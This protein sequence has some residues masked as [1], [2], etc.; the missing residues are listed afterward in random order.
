VLRGR[1]PG[2]GSTSITLRP[3]QLHSAIRSQVEVLI[4]MKLLGKLD[5]QAI[6]EWVRLHA[7][8]EE[9]RELK[10]SLPSLPVGTGWFWSPGWLEIMAKVHV[11]P[12]RT[13]DSSATPRVGQQRV[14]PRE[15]APVNPADL[16]RLAARLRTA[17]AA[18]VPGKPA[19]DV[20]RLSAELARL[21]AQLAEASQRE[22][23]RV[24]V[25]VL[26][27]GDIAALEQAVTGLRDVAGSIELALS[28]AV[29]PPS[30][31]PVP[32]SAPK[33]APTPAVARPPRSAPA[34]VSA[35]APLKPGA[36]R[37]LEALARRHPLRVTRPQLATLAGMKRTG[38]AFQAYFS[39]L[40]GAGFIAEA[41]G[42][43]SV[44]PD[45]LASAGL[46]P[47]AEPLTAEDLRETWKNTLKPKAWA[48][49]ECLLVAYPEARTK[50][51]LAEAVGMTVTGGGFQGYLTTLSTNDLVSV[52][53]D[54][55]RAADAFFL[56]DAVEV[57]GSRGT[58]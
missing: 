18:E 29:R 57:R 33:A 21:R 6:D 5:V 31:S 53:S 23:E 15:F 44:T 26:A 38:G 37:V 46:D 45:G 14:V 35:D 27:P 3:A 12:R 8:E 42:L 47:G 11:R 55:V 19:G 32:A 25:P 40:R 51:E 34:R 52:G 28:R 10:A 4:A 54:G 50:T 16:E 48:V 17:P 24:E 43:I 30:P 20:K 49:L 56:G 9:A 1:K 39:A 2:I 7:T 41:G 13:F 22:P 58:A 36:L